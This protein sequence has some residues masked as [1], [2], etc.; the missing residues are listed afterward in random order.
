MTSATAI[1]QIRTMSLSKKIKI[2]LDETRILIL[3]SQILLGF[4][5]QIAFRPGFQ[6]PPAR[7]RIAEA[8]ALALITLAA[9]LIITPSAQHRIV[10][11]G[12]DTKRLLNEIRRCAAWALAPFAAALGLD[13]FLVAERVLGMALEPLQASFSAASPRRSGTAWNG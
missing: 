2:G 11:G 9:G 12:E 13:I 10:E 5:F 3:G 4:E 1:C 6:T 8:A 7:D